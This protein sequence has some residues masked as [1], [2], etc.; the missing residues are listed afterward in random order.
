MLNAV[1]HRALPFLAGLDIEPLMFDLTDGLRTR[2]VSVRL[3]P[4]KVRYD[5]EQLAY[6]PAFDLQAPCFVFNPQ[7][8]VVNPFS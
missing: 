5:P 2:A 7:F 6:V 8:I 1:L 4:R 3:V